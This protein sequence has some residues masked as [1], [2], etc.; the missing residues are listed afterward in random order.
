MLFANLLFVIESFFCFCYDMFA[1]CYLKHIWRG[2]M[3]SP[4]A[5]FQNKPDVLNCVRY[6]RTQRKQVRLTSCTHPLE[7]TTVAPVIQCLQTSVH[8]P[9]VCYRTRLRARFRFSAFHLAAVIHAC[10]HWLVL[11]VS[12]PLCEFDPFTLGGIGSVPFRNC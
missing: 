11:H 1:H 8:L 12:T 10:L 3:L 5:G 7:K 9:S 4:K 2:P 6:E